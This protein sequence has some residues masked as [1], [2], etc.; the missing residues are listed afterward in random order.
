MAL[1][2]ERKFLIKKLPVETLLDMGAKVKEIEQAFLVPDKDFPV[3]RIRMVEEDGCRR[4]FFTLKRPTNGEFTRE[5]IE[6]EIGLE[7]YLELQKERDFALNI[8]FKKRYVIAKNAL[9]YEIDRFPFFRNFDMM[10]IELP[11]EDTPYEVP[12]EIEIINIIESSTNTTL[13]DM[14]VKLLSRERIL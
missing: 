3:R 11:S 6:R 12:K 13:S 8:I 1:E 10:E 7:L 5:E 2:I 4:Y 9:N 14:I